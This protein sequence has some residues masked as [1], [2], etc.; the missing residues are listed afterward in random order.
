MSREKHKKVFHILK[1]GAIEPF[2][3]TGFHVTRGHNVKFTV[4]SETGIHEYHF[5]LN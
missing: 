3:V 1:K 2:E 5:I 4:L